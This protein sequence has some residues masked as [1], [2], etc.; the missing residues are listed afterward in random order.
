MS[1]IRG[2]MFSA[3]RCKFPL[4]TCVLMSNSLYSLLAVTNRFLS[5]FTTKKFLQTKFFGN[6]NL[7][8]KLRL[9]T[10]TKRDFNVQYQGQGC[11]YE[12]L[13]QT[14]TRHRIP[15]QRLR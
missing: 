6:L 2:V 7:N 5:P 4:I 8:L 14:K 10:V 11:I 15:Q 9:H 12:P 1:M 13:D 3:L